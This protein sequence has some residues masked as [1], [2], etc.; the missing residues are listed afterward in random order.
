[1]RMMTMM[2]MIMMMMMMMMT[3]TMIMAMMMKSATAMMIGSSFFPQVK[4]TLPFGVLSGSSARIWWLSSFSTYA[5][6]HHHDC[7]VIIIV[8]MIVI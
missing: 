5:I 2:M 1:M 8:I 7:H 4:A 6:C 3:M